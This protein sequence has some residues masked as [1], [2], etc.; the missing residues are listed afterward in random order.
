MHIAE[1]FAKP[2]L[3]RRDQAVLAVGVLVLL[4]Y[5]VWRWWGAGAPLVELDTLPRREAQFQVDINTADWPE[6]TILPDIGESLAKRI[7][8][9]RTEHGPFRRHEDLTAVD[10]IGAATLNGI[11]PYLAPIAPP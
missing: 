7:V 5:L 4:A 9:Y 1:L 3:R 11:R 6:L 8:K 10:G 2:W